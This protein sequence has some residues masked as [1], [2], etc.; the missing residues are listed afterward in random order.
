MLGKCRKEALLILQKSI[1]IALLLAVSSVLAEIKVVTFGD[2]LLAGYGLEEKQG[3]T[4]QLQKYLDKA[5]L[6][7]KVMNLSVS[8]NTTADGLNRLRQV[9]RSKPDVVLLGLGSNDALRRLPPSVTYKNLKEIVGGLKESGVT[10]LLLGA[11]APFNWGLEYK[12][13]FDIIYTRLAE[14]EDLSLYP[15][16]LDGVALDPKYVL[17]DG[18]HPNAAGVG[19]MTSK[20]AP[21]VATIVASMAN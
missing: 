3:F 12:R 9:I 7:A 2:S 15:F 18:L 4:V 5:G 8:G 14:E 6:D 11:Q 16:I 20:I 13:D 21:K 19:I 17:P 1:V 10:V